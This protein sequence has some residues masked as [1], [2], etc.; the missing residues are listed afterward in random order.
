MPETVLSDK[1]D[2]VYKVGMKHLWLLLSALFLTPAPAMAEPP[3]TVIED[4]AEA[5]LLLGKHLFADP[6]ISYVGNM[7]SYSSFGEAVVTRKESVFF[8]DVNFECYSQQPFSYFEP[9]GGYINLKGNI[10][11]ITKNQFVLEGIIKFFYLPSSSGKSRGRLCE[12]NGEFTFS[13][14]HDYPED[15]DKDFWVLITPKNYID[16]NKQQLIDIDCG[17]YIEPISIFTDKINKPIENSSC[18]PDLSDFYKLD[19]PYNYRLS[20]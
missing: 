8:L 3:R 20:R 13:R 2:F 17:R 7:G 15:I 19:D 14:Q 9:K 10:L 1:R 12:K 18:V 5:D 4:Q 6:K 11:S 16:D